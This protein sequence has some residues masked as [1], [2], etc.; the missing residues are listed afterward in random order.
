[1][2]DENCNT[3]HWALQGRPENGIRHDAAI[4]QTRICESA[5]QPGVWV[6]AF[7]RSGALADP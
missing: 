5:A 7:A 1:M 4:N 6:Q 2:D 3:Y